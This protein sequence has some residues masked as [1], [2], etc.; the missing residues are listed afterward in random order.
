MTVTNIL[1]HFP[2]K[3]F[4]LCD[5][6]PTYSLIKSINQKLSANTSAI[7]STS[8]DRHHGLLRLTLPLGANGNFLFFKP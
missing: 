8:P 4:N 6:R 7:H 2:H 3:E 1:D 5:C